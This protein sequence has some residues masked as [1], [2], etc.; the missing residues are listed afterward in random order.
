VLEDVDC[1]IFYI[2]CCLLILKNTVITRLNVRKII[3]YL[4]LWGTQ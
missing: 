2:S 3:V 4:D 1:Q